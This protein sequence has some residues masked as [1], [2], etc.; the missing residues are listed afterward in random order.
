MQVIVAVVDLSVG[1]AVLLLYV[2]S[3]V[4]IR[5]G[6]LRSTEAWRAANGVEER[7]G[8]QRLHV[9]D[10]ARRQAQARQT[11]QVGQTTVAD[12]V[13][14]ERLRTDVRVLDLAFPVAGVARADQEFIEEAVEVLGEIELGV[15]VLGLV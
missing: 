3:V 14:G 2:P 4:P 15:G 11:G 12:L 6:V 5:V 13:E 8:T 9:G 10:H 7:A 1:C